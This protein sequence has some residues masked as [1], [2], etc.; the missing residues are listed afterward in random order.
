ME[1]AELRLQ[2]FVCS[3]NTMREA[4]S[5]RATASQQQQQQQQQPAAGSSSSQIHQSITLH[6]KRSGNLSLPHRAAV[7]R[8]SHSPPARA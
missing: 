6:T 3:H 8:C 1:V 5:A 4:T 2:C 7:C